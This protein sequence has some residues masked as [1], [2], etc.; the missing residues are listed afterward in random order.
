[1]STQCGELNGKLRRVF[2]TSDR[3]K[4]VA[5]LELDGGAYT[6]SSVAL[7]SLD[8]PVK[9]EPAATPGLARL[10]GTWRAN[11]NVADEPDP[12]TI[13]LALDERG[14]LIG[15]YMPMHDGA[16]EFAGV[17]SLSDGD[18][19]LS[20]AT[21]RNRDA[22]CMHGALQPGYRITSLTADKLVLE[23]IAKRRGFATLTFSRR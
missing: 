17:A 11:T 12:V 7:F 21:S 3:S 4:L 16:C 14:R 5:V 18:Q 13:E 10:A 23:P 19:I 6:G 22:E 9:P 15:S 20:L 2:V 8:A 1:L